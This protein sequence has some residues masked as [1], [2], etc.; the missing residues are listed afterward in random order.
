MDVKANICFEVSFE[1]AN[2]VGGIYTVIKSKAAQMQRHYKQYFLIGPYF[3]E[4]AQFDVD[5]K[6]PPKLWKAIFDDLRKEG[7]ECYWGTWLIESRPNV[8][9]VDSKKLAPEKDNWKRFWWERFQIDSLES[10]WDFE[11]PMIWS[12]AVGRLIE[13]FLVDSAGDKVVLHAHEWLAGFSLLWLKNQQLPVAKVFTTHATMLGRSLASRGTDLYKQLQHLQP[14]IEARNLGI[15]SKFS[16]EKICAAQADIFTTVSEATAYEAQK[17]LGRRPEVLTINGLDSDEFPLM[18]ELSVMHDRTKE[19]LQEF[20]SYY[21][22][23]YSDQ[24]FDLNNTFTF[25][26]VGRYE[27]HNK[28]LDVFLDSLALLNE[29]LKST[30]SKKTVVAMIWVPAGIGRM[31]NEVLES[32]N[33]YSHIK[34]YTSWNQDKIVKSLITQ[35]LSKNEV[36]VKELLPD[37]YLLAVKKDVWKFHRQGTPPLCTH[38][39]EDEG[40]DP[41]IGQLKSLGLTNKPEDRVKV[42]FY[43]VYL[44]GHDGLLNLSYYDA[45]AGGDLGVFAS[46]YEPWGYTPI[47]AAAMAIPAVTTDLAGCGIYLEQKVSGSRPGIKV[48][49]RRGRSQ[50]ETVSQLLKHFEDFL[51]QTPFERSQQRMAAKKAVVHADWKELIINYI[52]AHNQ[53]WQ[54][55]ER[56]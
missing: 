23:P 42:V 1:V 24:A 34:N 45:M 18:E 9:L 4:K 37:D 28:G 56:S 6:E 21:F 27:Y 20:Y 3:K 30:A 39:L 46:Y 41:I 22:F 26:T 7:I 11:E 2:K 19:R 12:T 43:P 52:D 53:A 5:I 10:G 8:I 29:R 31:R 38:Y 44:D 32:K 36:D 13:R 54:K 50:E 40:G 47:E 16:T 14:E 17:V 55:V 35:L 49:G 33:Y 48:I 51:S 25:F 15:A